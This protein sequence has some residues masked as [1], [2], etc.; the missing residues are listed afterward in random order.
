MIRRKNLKSSNSG[1]SESNSSPLATSNSITHPGSA[2][3]L[4]QTQQQL[5]YNQFFDMRHGMLLNCVNALL[6]KEL[7]RD[8]L[9]GE[10]RSNS[11]ENYY[12]TL[13][14]HIYIHIQTY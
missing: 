12:I 14:Q 4:R 6:R 11:F 2:S 13:I 1:N 5:S 10:F 3:I 7:C 8:T 9:S